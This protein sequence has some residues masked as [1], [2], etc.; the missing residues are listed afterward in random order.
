MPHAYGKYAGVAITKSWRLF[1]TP[2][3]LFNQF[4][5][6]ISDQKTSIKDV[7]HEP[8]SARTFGDKGPCP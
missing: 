4:I 8:S 5:S 2:L 6:E 7:K 3:F 1:L